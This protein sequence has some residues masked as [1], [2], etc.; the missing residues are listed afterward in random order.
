VPLTFECSD[1]GDVDPACDPGRNDFLAPDNI[2]I[3]D[4]GQILRP[5][6]DFYK[7]DIEICTIILQLPQTPLDEA[8][9]DVF[10]KL[11]ADR[12]D[13][14]TSAAYPACRYSDCSTVQPED[15]AGGK[16]RFGVSLQS[17]VPSLDG[18]S[19]VDGY[20]AIID[21]IIGVNM[22]QD[23][24][25]LR[26]TVQDLVV[27]PVFVTLVTKIQINVFLKKSGWNNQVLV[28]DSDDIVGLVST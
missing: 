9:I 22:D 23:N 7:P 25:I 18:Y 21:D 14:F 5:N 24:G 3:G 26:L 19:L 2:I 8:N 27:D 6:G 17:F 10:N 28:V 1:R 20:G 11:V 4:G 12:G 15:L 13:G 16:V